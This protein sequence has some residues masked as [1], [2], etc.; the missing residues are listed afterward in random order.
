MEGRE[1]KLQR[2]ESLS[3]RL[4]EASRAYYGRDVELMDNRQY[5]ALYEEL[6]ALE[7]E[8]G[9]ILPG[10]PSLQV[11]AAPEEGEEYAVWSLLPKEAHGKPMLSLD[12]TKDRQ[13]LAAWLGGQKGQLSWKLDGLTMVL[14]YREGKLEKALTRGDGQVGE[15]VTHNAQV[16]VNLPREISFKG[17]LVLRGEAV[18]SYEDFAAVNAALDQTQ[19]LYKNPRNL[20][21]G[22]VRQLDSR[23][24]AGRRVAFYAFGLVEPQDLPCYGSKGEQLAF[25]AS[26]GFAVVESVAV[27]GENLLAAVEDFSARVESYSLPTDGLV[28]ALEDV[29]YGE[30]LGR[31]AKFPRDSIA[32]KWQD[33]AVETTLLE[34]EWSCSR[35]GLLNPVAVFDPVD[36]DGS[37]VSRASLHNLSQ[38]QALE[39]GIGD[40]I[41]VY[42]ANKIIPQVSDNLT[43]SGGLEPPALCPVCRTAVVEERDRDVALLRCPNKACPAKGLGAFVLF[44]GRSGLGIEGLSEATLE[45]WIQAGFLRD[46]PDLFSLEAHREAIVAM[47]GF[48]ERSYE[49]IHNALEKARDCSMQ[50]LVSAL[51]L[52]GIGP[53]LAGELAAYFGGDMLAF[54]RAGEEELLQIEGI[55]GVLAGGIARYWREEANVLRLE[56]LLAHLRIPRQEAGERPLAGLTFVITGSITMEGGRAGLKA[57]IEAL[58]G[59]VAG[60]V[61]QKTSALINNDA[62][63]ASA[64]NKKALALGVPVLDEEAFAAAYLP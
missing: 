30:S 62:A 36:L 63:S 43:R 42:K 46:L 1:A 5:D 26:Q 48:G 50:K 61:S 19:A 25:L 57:R 41:L 4:S 32:F 18:I 54:A 44:A 8:L 49:N 12:K 22:S 53:A 38:A 15:V 7:A 64:K 29:A 20:C 40:R 23:V 59:K 37:R 21:S 45:K 51:G 52:P 3:L 10:S 27:D 17:R 35:T 2:L 34:V 33:E 11:G 13:A 56:A 9:L 6:Q 55:G 24:T 31:T 16:F 28:L 60:S 39:L 47:E 58:G 14:H